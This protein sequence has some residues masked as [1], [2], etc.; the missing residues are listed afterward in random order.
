MN[1]QLKAKIFLIIAGIFLLSSCAAGAEPDDNFSLYPAKIV[2]VIDGDTVKV[3]F[4][5]EIP[6]GCEETETVRLIGVNTPE[7]N[8]CNDEEPEYYALEAYMYTNCYYGGSVFIELDDVSSL[9]DKY[10]RML[11][12]VWLASGTMLNKNLI[13]DGYGFFYGYFKFN[14]D[15]MDSFF[16]AEQN[17]RQEKKGMWGD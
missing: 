7:L 14:S 15:Y 12:Y 4:T 16:L 11:A 5:D 17:A 9:R 3:A 10:G 13:E 8:R 2:S 1:N 6:H